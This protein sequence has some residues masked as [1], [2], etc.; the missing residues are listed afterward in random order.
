LDIAIFTQYLI[1]FT[2]LYDTF[3]HFGTAS[4]VSS[5]AQIQIQNRLRAESSSWPDAAL[6]ELTEDIGGSNRL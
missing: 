6:E 2:N 4:S 1:V 3:G 5:C